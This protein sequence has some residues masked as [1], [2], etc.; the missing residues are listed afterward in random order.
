[1]SISLPD[2][3]INLTLASCVLTGF[4]ALAPIPTQGAIRIWQGTTDN[5]WATGT[6][7]NASPGPGSVD[8]ATFNSAGGAIDTIDVGTGL[9]VRDVQF[10]TSNAAAYTLGTEAVGSQTMT[11][12]DGGVVIVVSNVVKDQLFNANVLLGTATASNYTFTNDS[13]T[14]SLTFAGNVQGGAGGTAGAKALAVNGFGNTFISGVIANG[15]AGSLTLIKAGTGILTLS[16]SAN[17]YTGTTTIQVGTLRSGAND[18]LPGAVSIGS[19]GNDATLDLNNFDDTISSLAFGAFSA[20]KTASIS[21][22]TGTLTLDGGITQDAGAL[23][24]KVIS[25]KL[26]LGGGTRTIANAGATALTISALISNG[27]ISN[28]S[29]LV[30]SGANTYASGTTLTSGS[31][32]VAVESAG[33]VGS[34]TS[35]AIGTGT[36]TFGGGTISSDGATART[37]LNAVNFTASAA[38]GIGDATKNG[39]MTIAGGIDLGTTSHTITVNSAANFDGSLT[40]TGGAFTKAGAGTLTLSNT[41]NAHTGTTG[42]SAGILRSGASNVLADGSTLSI[43]GIGTLDLAG[44]SDTV[45]GDGGNALHLGANSVGQTATLSTGAGTLTLGG[46]IAT[47][48]NALGNQLISGNLSLGAA[49]RSISL[50]V[51]GNAAKTLTISAIVTGSVG[52]GLTLQGGSGATLLLNNANTYSGPTTLTANTLA[53]GTGN[54]GTVGAITSSPI[55]TGTLIF[56]GGG[57]SSDGATARTVLNPVNFTGNAVIGTPSS[58]GKITFSDAATL[59]TAVRTITVESEGQFDGILSGTGGGISKAGS[60]T[61]TLTA[62]NTY[63]GATSVTAGRLVFSGNNSAATGGT[64][65]SGG[66]LQ[67][68]SLASINGTTRNATITGP[69]VLVFGSGFGSANIPTALLTRVVDSSAGAVATDN[70]AAADFDFGTAGL[71]AASLGA[72]GNV[73]YTGTLS[74]SANTYRLG[75]GG[76]TLVFTPAAYTN[77]HDLVINGNGNTGTV[78]FGGLSKTFDDITFGAGTTQNGTLTGTTFAAAGG[79]TITAS[80]TGSGNF[81]VS[82]GTTVLNGNNSGYS[83]SFNLTGGSLKAVAPTSLGTGSVT[84]NGGNLILSNDGTGAGLGNGNLQSINYGTDVVMVGDRMITV[85]RFTPTPTGSLNAAN[86]ILQLD[87]LSLPANTLTVINSNGYGLEFTGTTTLTGATATTI[88]VAA[89]NVSTGVM[90]LTLNGVTSAGSTSSTAGAVILTKSGLGTLMLKGTNTTF[91]G[92]GSA[93]GQIIDITNGMLAAATDAALGKTGAT[94]NVVQISANSSTQGFLATGTFATDRPF[95]L[96]AAANGIDVTQGNTLTLTTGFQ[97][98]AVSNGL[99]K[100]DV[101]TLE[102]NNDNSTMTGN[103][104]VN[105]GNLKVS[106]ANALGAAGTTSNG[107]TQVLQN[108]PAGVQLNGVSIG[109]HFKIGSFG[110]NNSGGL[111]AVGGAASTITGTLEIPTEA[112][113]GADVSSTLNINGSVPVTSSGAINMVGAGTVSI[114]TSITGTTNGISHYG[115]GTSI[116]NNAAVGNLYNRQFNV[117]A[118]RSVTLQG[119]QATRVSTG[120]GPNGA[121]AVNGGSVTFDNVTGGTAVA[122]RLG[123]TFT[124]PNFSQATVTLTGGGSVGEA[125]G[126]VTFGSGVTSLVTTG[127][128]A[129]NVLSFTSQTALNTGAAVTVSSSG[130]SS[131][132]FATTAPSLND[133][134]LPGWYVGQDFATHGGANTAITAFSAYATGDLGSLAT[135]TAT[136]LRLFGAQTQLTAD[137]TVNTLKLISALGIEMAATKTLTVDAGGLINDGGGNISGGTLTSTS[138][139]MAAYTG[140]GSISSIIAGTNGLTKLGVGNLTLTA[141]NNYTGQ[142]TVNQ[143]TLTL[144]GGTNTLAGNQAL[145]LN[146][147]NLVLGSNNQYVGNLTSNTIAGLGASG[148]GG[149]VTGS[150]TLTTNAANGVF[151]GNISG[152]VNFIKAGANTLI[153][154][155]PNDTTGSITVMGGGVTLRDNATLLNASSVAV[156]GGT[157]LLDN[158][159]GL[160]ASRDLG[161]RVGDSTAVT[162]ESGTINYQGRVGWHSSETLGAVTAMGGLNTIHAVPGGIG[163]NSVQLTLT[164]LARTTGAMV[165]LKGGTAHLGA[166]GNSPRVLVSGTNLPTSNG[167]VIGAF[168]NTDVETF[169]LVGYASGMGFGPLGQAGFPAYTS[170]WSTADGT[171]NLNAG[172]TVASGGQTINS[173]NPAANGANPT[174]ISFVGGS[175]TLT[176]NSG[177]VLLGGNNGIPVANVGSTAI[178]GALTTGAGQ[179]ELFL[180]SR[181][182]N[183]NKIPVHSI[184]KDN[185]S[186]VALVIANPGGAAAQNVQLTGVNTHTGGTYVSG[187]LDL[188]AT[189]VGDVVIPY[190]SGNGDAGAHGLVINSG[191]VTMLTNAGQIHSS[192]TVTLNGSGALTLV[193][194]NTLANV[195]FNSNG[196]TAAP[197]LTPTGVL[198]I[199]GDISSAPTNVSVTPIISA[200]TL[201]LNNS[202]S[203]SITVS[204][205]PTGNTI[206]SGVNLQGQSGLTISSAIQNG[207]FTKRGTGVLNLTGSSNFAG[208]LTIEEGAVS[209]ATVNNVSANGPLG[210]SA[211]AVTMGGSLNKVGTLEYTGGNASSSKPFTMATGGAGA[212][213]IDTQATTLTLTGLLN[214]DGAFMKTGPGTVTL[215]N[216]TASNT[217]AGDTIITQGTLKIGSAAFSQI[218]RG[219]GKGNVVLNGAAFTAGILDIN[220]FDITVNGL[221]GT[222]GTVPGQVTNNTAGAKTLT[223]GDGDVSA[224][225]AG[226]I[227]NGTGT[228]AL[229]KIGAGNQ[230]LAGIN[231]YTGATSVDAGTLLVDGSITSSAI[232]VKNGGT[233]GGTGIVGQNVSLLAGGVIAPGNSP[234]TLTVGGMTTTGAGQFNFQLNGVIAGTEYDQLII[235]STSGGSG[236]VNL[237]AA[238]LNITLG[239]SPATF[240]QFDLIINDGTDA[241]TG[242]FFNGATQLNEGDLFTAAGRQWQITYVAGTGN[243]VRLIAIPE[244]SIVCLAA[245]SFFLFKR[246]RLA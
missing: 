45:N 189:T 51:S 222:S 224:T 163:A 129:G 103:F 3:R 93:T 10:S 155:N 226:V 147:G 160:N 107:F 159:G 184:I 96:N 200:G 177:M 36:L 205:L 233:L 234:G 88:N 24:S 16:S 130:S 102:L 27:G 125:M 124:I 55:G 85:E 219:T 157:F 34:I 208:M 142:T 215:T 246:R 35:S 212:F 80:L 172:G 173:A 54:V 137:K 169:N 134:I 227:R 37:I 95:K 70:F 239:Y 99:Q 74:A 7:W 181:Q 194:N 211:N 81:A 1:M 11:I 63:T 29:N 237:G 58:L 94:G 128:D 32:E 139:L 41:G 138:A 158:G 120:T 71:T 64:T 115:P 168:T 9:V 230:T 79:A 82:G 174:S 220:N 165:Y 210:N 187:G 186:P 152:S 218:P 112:S 31:L 101:G 8:Q 46:N 44:F 236:L 12:N 118:G 199:T 50:G 231:T 232:T 140:N 150:G 209:V 15:G 197:A 126:A 61:L 178:R 206:A 153:L 166:V 202:S 170:N 213:Q 22:G 56:N 238:V 19:G 207:G 104:V 244:P 30:L 62:D 2:P 86:K 21:T 183:T 84:L 201:N 190:S 136:N 145:V 47:D 52:S 204:A 162:L 196:G 241:V 223:V 72:V 26:S 131:V 43:A 192:N 180:V 216:T 135:S 53:F 68:N 143:G 146:G 57:I 14:N 23:G 110:M 240:D 228:V 121:F 114:N 113:L 90:G 141:P 193:G 242:N 77:T 144:A 69:G 42:V 203:H 133:L 91:G 67:V 78:D 5:V 122:N 4:T 214:G 17:S 106:N 185:G 156:R 176:V 60:G 221:S 182:G 89:A 229:T 33:S 191:T 66:E 111:Q 154:T 167:V 132:R 109:E 225:F 243:D 40:G 28:G 49:T 20:L 92:N 59:G 217:Y 98:S 18:V 13:S 235:D 171:S 83:G 39:V 195:V 97:L 6:N 198:T 164:S 105:Q 123:G 161:N 48:G 245:F 149:T 38:A 76:G 73:T 188:N 117:Y 25:G 75:G 65:V 116:F 127:S 119:A 108:A 100:N 151:A 179:Q 87:A 175:D 148:S